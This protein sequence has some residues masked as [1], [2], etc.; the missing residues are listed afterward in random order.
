MKKE[1]ALGAGR[2][3]SCNRDYILDTR[4][5]QTISRTRSVVGSTKCS[6]KKVEEHREEA[7]ESSFAEDRGL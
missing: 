2:S 6:G 4:K 7:V 1:D 5:V 3:N